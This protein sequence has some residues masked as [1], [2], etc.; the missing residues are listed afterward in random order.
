[1]CRWVTGE[2]SRHILSLSSRSRH[3]YIFS[4]LAASWILF[5]WIFMDASVHKHDGLNPWPLVISLTFCLILFSK[6]WGLGLKASA[7]THLLV[8]QRISPILKLPR[9]PASSGLVSIQNTHPTGIAGAK[10]PEKRWRPMS[11][12]SPSGFSYQALFFFFF[13]TVSVWALLAL[14]SQFS[15]AAGVLGL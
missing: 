4:H 5:F 14:I 8:F 2:G 15:P 7:S 10:C 3:I 11:H 12:L 6:G 13:E 1:M 9:V